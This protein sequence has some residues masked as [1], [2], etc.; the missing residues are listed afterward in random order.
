MALAAPTGRAA[1][2]MSEVTEREAKNHS[3]AFRGGMGRNDHPV[4][5]RNEKNLLDCD[6]LILDELSM[7]DA[8]VFEGC[9]GRCL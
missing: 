2:R 7:V 3:P 6:A 9:S 8:Q 5:T 4:F 1:Q